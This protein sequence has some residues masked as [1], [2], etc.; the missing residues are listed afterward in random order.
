MKTLL[1][2]LVLSAAF[3]IAG[4]AYRYPASDALWKGDPIRVPREF[5]IGTATRAQAEAW[6]RSLIGEPIEKSVTHTEELDLNQDGAKELLLEDQRSCGGT[7][8]NTHFAFERTSK[9]YRYVGMLGYVGIE[10]IPRG[11]TLGPLIFTSWH[12]SSRESGVGLT[13]WDASGFHS[14]ASADAIFDEP[15]EGEVTLLNVQGKSPAAME[16]LRRKFSSNAKR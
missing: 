12:M 9:G 14:V 15:A 6:T 4:C 10:V 3:G 11:E 13:E 7:G 16:A 5:R 8:N 1:C 2:T